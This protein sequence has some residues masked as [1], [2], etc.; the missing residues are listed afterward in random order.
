MSDL[1]GWQIAA[2]VL[3]AIFIAALL[4]ATWV[5]IES[6]LHAKRLRR[7]Q[8][9]TNEQRQRQDAP[10]EQMPRRPKFLP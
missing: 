6:R 3:A 5:F 4:F 10:T 7:L 2:C 1:S 8:R 9:E